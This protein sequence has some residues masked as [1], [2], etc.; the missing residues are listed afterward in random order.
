MRRYCILWGM[1]A[2]PSNDMRITLASVFT[3]HMV[4]QQGIPVSVWGTARP[5]NM[6]RVMF[7]GQV[8]TTGV[9]SDGR[10]HL[11]L[12]P[13][14]Y[15]SEPRT[16]SAGYA[17]PAE[18][19][20]ESETNYVEDILVGEVWF[21]SGQSNM[22]MGMSETADRDK[23]LRDAVYPGI[24]LY[25]IKKN[26]SPFPVERISSRWHECN[27]KAL[28]AYRWDGFSAVA[29]F[30]GRRLHKE[31]GVPVG[32]IQSAFGGSRIHPWIPK[33]ALKGIAALRKEY[34]LL[35]RADREYAEAVKVSAGAVHAF[36]GNNEYSRLKPATLFNAMVFPVLPFVIRGLL[37]YQG[38]SNVGEGMA[39]AEKMKA[40]I[41]GWRKKFGRRDLPFYY[42]QIPPYDY[43]EETLL[44]SLWEAQEACLSIPHTGM[45]TAVDM[46]DPKELHPPRKR[47]IGERLA[48]LSLWDTYGRNDVRWSGPVFSGIRIEGNIA[49]ISFDHTEG[50]LASSDG[51]PLS[52]FAIAGPD[53][54]F[55]PARAEIH[56]TT[57]AVKSERVK[58]PAFVR[59]AWTNTSLPNLC[60]GAGLPARPF[61]TDTC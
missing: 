26:A 1:M 39:Y 6:I 27:P 38:E 17:S 36:S 52:C 2:E 7:A 46:G 56:G 61:R 40:L 13:L 12:D 11:S 22:E 42:V 44:P 54:I 58:V 15:S 34:E 9:T 33:E 48:L 8:K 20:P 55:V 50:G 25:H 32:L 4:L 30:F 16:L 53:G 31:L 43:G 19:S 23:E 59:F 41:S 5:G 3:H 21:C 14:E 24:R 28:T 57:V 51:K 37:W 45:I 49:V 47:E 29:F 60:N 35:E 18:K 10:W